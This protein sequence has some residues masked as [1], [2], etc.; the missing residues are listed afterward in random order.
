VPDGLGQRI[1]FGGSSPSVAILD[2][3][4]EPVH[5][6]AAGTANTPAGSALH[7]NCDGDIALDASSVDAQRDG[8]HV[9][10]VDGILD[11]DVTVTVNAI[12][13][14]DPV[15]PPE[16]ISAQ[17]VVHEVWAFAPGTYE[18][19]CAYQD[20]PGGSAHHATASVAIA[21]PNNLY[22]APEL[23]CSNGYG[24]ATASAGGPPMRERGEPTDIV[25]EHLSGLTTADALTR[26]GY[27]DQLDPVVGVVRDGTVVGTVSFAAADGGWV[28]TQLEGCDGTRFSWD[29]SAQGGATGPIGASPSPTVGVE[30]SGF[31]GVLCDS[32]NAEVS[33]D[34]HVDVV[35]LPDGPGPCVTAL[36]LLAPADTTLHILLTNEDAGVPRNL[37]IYAMTPCLENELG[38]DAIG[39]DPGAPL[40]RGDPIDG[41]NPVETVYDVPALTAG[42]YWIQD[43][44]HPDQ[45]HGVLKVAPA[46]AS[47]SPT[48][49]PS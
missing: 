10:I 2:A 28:F 23:G 19:T 16:T 13:A 17:G 9:T 41:V 32:N 14:S 26:L 40:F 38:G 12:G 29:A 1:I 46:G 8:A 30:R 49:S 36:R 48:P 11:Q 27:P 39:C 3:F 6:P 21:D 31:V 44:L 20:G 34:L 42:R 18:V 4:A 45:I 22:H 43:D 35:R 25:H 7:V 15:R 47:L 37:A 24:S 5:L 33:A